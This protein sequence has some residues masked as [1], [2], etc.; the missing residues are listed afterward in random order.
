MR[1]PS[2][3]RWSRACTY[4]PFDRPSVVLDFHLYP[5]FKFSSI[6]FHVG[7]CCFGL[8]QQ[9]VH[10]HPHVH[11]LRICALACELQPLCKIERMRRTACAAHN[12]C[13]CLTCIGSEK[14]KRGNC[15]RAR[16]R[17]QERQSVEVALTCSE[18]GPHARTSHCFCIFGGG[19]S[20]V[21]VP[22]TL[23]NLAML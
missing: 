22:S 16:S 1:S 8:R 2:R 14:R 12:S 9:C 3:L 11:A 4:V 19:C 18:G 17:L 20:S 10:I 6:C 13:F 15:R 7:F 5:L 23:S 21:L